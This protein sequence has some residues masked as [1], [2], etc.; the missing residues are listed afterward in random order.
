VE[1]VGTRVF[2]PASLL[3]FLSGLGLVLDS[4]FWGFGDDWIIIGLVLFAVTFL[5]GLLF[6][7]PESGRIGKLVASEGPASPSAQ[8]RIRRILALSRADLVLLFLILFDMA[9]KPSFD[10][11]WLY[12]AILVAAAVAAI[13]VRSGLKAQSAAAAAPQV[14][15]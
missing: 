5:A 10:D 1:W 14:A 11:A 15:D 4:D 12:V 7:G 6:F 9:V 3:A 8:A 13:L 2:A